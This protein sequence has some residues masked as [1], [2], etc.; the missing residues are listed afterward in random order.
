MKTEVIS[1]SELYFEHKLWKRELLFWKDELNSF[2]NRLD[3][4]VNRWTNKDVLI[5]LEH[6]QNQFIIHENKIIELRQ[7]IDAH[8]INIAENS[9]KDK[10]ILNMELVK[11]H[12]ECRNHL[13]TERHMY[14]ELK[15]DFFRFLSKYM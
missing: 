13:E 9:K 11:K 3:E 14:N 12:I 6:Y 5:Q 8:E 7:I 10:D 15:K 1:N 2:K 4:L